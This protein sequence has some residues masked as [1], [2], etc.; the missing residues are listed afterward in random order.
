MLPDTFTV[1]YPQEFFIG[2]I[3]KYFRYRAVEE[4]E[5]RSIGLNIDRIS[6]VLEI[7]DWRELSQ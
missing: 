6:L 1:L 5:A 7:K 3:W 2:K 4:F